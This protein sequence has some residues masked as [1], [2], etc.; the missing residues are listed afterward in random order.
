H[1][2]NRTCNLQGNLFVMGMSWLALV[3]LAGLSVL[4]MYSNAVFAQDNLEL[5][6]EILEIEKPEQFD[7]IHTGF[8]LVGNHANLPCE[9][10]HQNGIYERLSHLC[11][12]C[13]NNI[14][15]VG[16]PQDHIASKAPCDTC[17]TT[18]VFGQNAGLRQHINLD[19]QCYDC[20]NN[21]LEMGK[22]PAH[23]ES[24]NECDACHNKNGWIPV[25]R[26]DHTQ[27][28]MGSCLFCHNN[29]YAR[30][31]DTASHLI[32][33]DA[34]EACHSAT[35]GSWILNYMD[36]TQVQS[37]CESCHNRILATGPEDRHLGIPVS[38]EA[39]HN[40][41][42][43]SSVIYDHSVLPN[44]RCAGCHNGNN[45]NG[46]SADHIA[47][48]D[49]CMLCHLTFVN[50]QTNTID[51]AEVRGFCRDCHIKPAKHKN[52]SAGCASCHTIDDWGNVAV[53]HSD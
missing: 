34:C 41:V 10:C 3:I 47:T 40:V 49:Q 30:G 17:H 24:S 26:V 48:S 28:F 8:P 35:I 46:K 19:G 21:E 7:H 18:E 23:I 25:T 29:T 44:M 31:K 11:A 53:K 36:H 42:D 43:W 4:A 37:R 20:H 5:H 1:G 2:G 32:T 6:L 38:C 50:W 27:L 52:V 39:C 22:P 16:K 15:A 9:Q 45:T 13:H 14:I 33:S 51:H 12:Y